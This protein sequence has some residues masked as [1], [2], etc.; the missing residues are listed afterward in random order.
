MRSSQTLSEELNRNRDTTA[1]LTCKG[2]TL[3]RE[4]LVN[5]AKLKRPRIARTK[6]RERRDFVSQATEVC[7]R[8]AGNLHSEN[9]FCLQVLYTNRTR[10]R[11]GFAYSIE[12]S[13]GVASKDPYQYLY[14]LERCFFCSS[15]IAYNTGY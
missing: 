9:A 3:L 13:I 6:V 14:I 1:L 8:E 5:I 15:I 12:D 4:F 11:P 10:R 2:C 7:Q